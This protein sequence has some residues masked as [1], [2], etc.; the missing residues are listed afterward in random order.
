MVYI[1]SAFVGDEKTARNITKSLQ[2]KIVGTS[3]K[4]HVDEKLIPVFDTVNKTE[5][6]L[7]EDRRIRAEAVKECGEAN[8]TCI[9]QTVDRLRQLK[10]RTIVDDGKTPTDPNASLKGLRLTVNILDDTGNRKRMVIPAGNDFELDG[11]SPIDPRKPGEWLP[12]TSFIRTKFIE[13]NVIVIT[14][15]LWVFSIVAAY[16]L[17]GRKWGVYAGVG[18]AFL[19]FLFPGS[20]YLFIFGYFGLNAFVDKYTT[21]V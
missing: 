16:T 12:P 7:V 19:A 20:G 3:I 18:L 14:T 2:D 15:F 13:F 10:L 1:E 8:T 11:L 9:T 17:F 5:I 4:V 6:D 21:M